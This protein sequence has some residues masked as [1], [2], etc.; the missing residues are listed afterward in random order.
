MPAPRVQCPRMVSSLDVSFDGA[1]NPQVA[2]LTAGHGLAGED[3]GGVV[4][5][6]LRGVGR[7]GRRRGRVEVS[8]QG[9]AYPGRDAGREAGLQGGH[10]V[11]SQT[12]AP[13]IVRIT[14]VISL[15]F[16]Q[17]LNQCGLK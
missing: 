2:N 17:S 15:R 11:I 5:P 12:R 16:I 1:R 7:Q 3:G 13:V 9:L 10:S 8:R 14:L 6:L 4:D